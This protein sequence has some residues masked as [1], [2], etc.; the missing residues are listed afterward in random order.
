VVD[1]LITAGKDFDFL[2]APGGVHGAGAAMGS[3]DR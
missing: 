2:D 1:R 3:G